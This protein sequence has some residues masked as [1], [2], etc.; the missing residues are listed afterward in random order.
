MTNPT[1]H[2]QVPEALLLADQY[3]AAHAKWALEDL[4][5]SSKS[6]TA[7]KLAERHAARKTLEKALRAQQPAPAEVVYSSPEEMFDAILTPQP[8]PTPQADS[9]PALDRARIR[10]IFM[11]HGFTVKEGQTDLKQYVYDAADAL[12]RAARKKGG[13]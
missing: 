13:A 11:A 6:Y 10:E 9:Q 5:G 12:L 8:S 4:Y 1:P 3:A 7:V 2:G